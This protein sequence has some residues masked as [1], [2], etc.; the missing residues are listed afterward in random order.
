MFNVPLSTWFMVFLC[1]KYIHYPF[2]HTI[3]PKTCYFQLSIHKMCKVKTQKQN[4]IPLNRCLTVSL[5]WVNVLL[6]GSL[7]E[8]EFAIQVAESFFVAFPVAIKVDQAVLSSLENLTRYKC[9][10][11]RTR[12]KDT[13]K[14]AV[15]P[16]VSIVDDTMKHWNVL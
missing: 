7:T 13:I 15:L 10:S 9:V 8:P 14:A 11:Y 3:S 2:Q 6:L 4:Y 5:G 16:C 1:I 12:R